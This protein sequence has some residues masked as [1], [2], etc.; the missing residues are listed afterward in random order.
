[1]G[2]T[3]EAQKARDKVARL[4]AIADSQRIAAN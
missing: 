2:R 4:Q 1:M 3:D